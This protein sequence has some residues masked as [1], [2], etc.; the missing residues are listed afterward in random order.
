ML[1]EIA[2]L[3]GEYV[4]TFSELPIAPVEPGKPVVEIDVRE[5]RAKL[6]DAGVNW[7]IINLSGRRVVVRSARATSTAPPMAMT[8]VAIGQASGSREPEATRDEFLASDIINQPTVRGT[9]AALILNQLQLPPIDLRLEFQRADAIV[10]D[11]NV[12]QSRFEVQPL[13]GPSSD[14]INLAVR[15]WR[16]SKVQETRYISVFP[17]RRVRAAALQRDVRTNQ[18]ITEADIVKSEQWLTPNQ[19]ALI[20]NQ[21]NV[22]GRIA[23]RN[24]KSGELLRESSVQREILIRRGDL[25]IVRCLVGGVA[26][27]LQA[28]ARGDGG[29]GETIEFRKQGER[30]TFLACVSRRG[31]AVLDLSRQSIGQ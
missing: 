5:V 27:S 4:R 18:A 1:G 6:D 23:A 26:I 2:E 17:Q 10:L 13:T 8:A 25:V 14:R 16:D 24:M 20:A 15:I 9:I 7:G 31:E 12:N 30:D 21:E 29:E 19:A 11:T 3:Q 28:E 22:V